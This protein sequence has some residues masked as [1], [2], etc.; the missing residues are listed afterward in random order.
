MGLLERKTNKKKEE[1]KLSSYFLGII[2]LATVPADAYEDSR[3]HL[4]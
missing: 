3:A 4:S 1:R 2:A